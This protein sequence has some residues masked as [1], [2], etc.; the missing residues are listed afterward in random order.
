MRLPALAVLATVLLAGCAGSRPA[1]ETAAVA[2]VAPAAAPADDNLNA[3]LWMQTAV[4]YRATA[5][6]VYRAA[7]AVLPRALA[8]TA[9]T[10]DPAQAARGG[11]GRLPVAVVLDADETV[12]DNSPFGAR[13]VRDGAAY[14]PAAWAAWV[15]EGR[16]RAVPGAVA[17]AQA[18]ARLG[19]RV[20]YLTNRTGAEE[21]PTVASLRRLGF[22]AADS[23]AVLTRGERAEWAAA[24]KGARR[25]FVTAT[26]RVVLYVGDNLGDFVS[27]EAA[28]VAARDALVA[29]Y[30]AY[31]GT[32][33]FML[34]NPTYGS[35]E[36]AL[37]RGTT[38][39]DAGRAAKR[40]ALRVE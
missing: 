26:H 40:A 15:N 16:E 10:A 21:A 32:R 36:G 1:A 7:E 20:V 23:G 4:E 33:W 34:P 5:L 3:V 27:G 28:P 14:S 39:A 11:Y 31:W 30:E 38:G 8:D 25:A 29:P 35:W 22:P 24:D 6:A 37:T 2:P 17:F 13:L 12:L 18:A 9:W 19:A